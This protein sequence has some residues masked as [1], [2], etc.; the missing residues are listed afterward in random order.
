MALGD[1][2]RRNIATVSEEERKRFVTAILKL[3]HERFFPDGTSC[4]DKQED[5]HKNAHAAGANVHV[6]PAFIPWHRELCNRFE[7]L[8]RE[9]DADLSLHYW[10]WTVDPRQAP[11]GAGGTLDLFTPSFMGGVGDPVGAPFGDFE[12]TEPGHTLIWR[13]VGAN[14]AKSDGSP[15][16]ST[17]AEIK[18]ALD[19]VAFDA[20]IR[21]PHGVAHAY[22]GGTLEDA[23][24]SFHDPFVFLLHSDLDRLWAEWQTDPAHPERLDPSTAYSSYG[25]ATSINEDI[26]P[27]AGDVGT[28]QAPLRPWGPP[29]NMQEVKTYKDISVVTPPCYDTLPRTVRVL[30]AE[31][32]GMQIRFDEV[33]E[34]ET[35]VRAAVFEVRACGEVTLRVSAGPSAPFSLHLPAD[36]VL[37]MPHRPQIRQIGRIW[38]RYTAGAAGV[39]VPPSDVTVHCEETGEDFVFHLRA[40]SIPRPTVAVMLALDQSGSMAWPAGID[41]TTKRIDVLH[42]AAASFVQLVQDNNGVGIVS[43]DQLAHPGTDVTRFGAGPF[44]PGRATALAAIQAIEPAGSTSIG[45]GLE[46]ARSTLD[47]VSGYDRKALVVFTDGLENTPL[48]ISDVAPTIDDRTFAIGLGTAQQVSAGALTSLT[49]HTQ[50]YLLLSGPLS[51]SVDDYFRLTKYFLQVLAGVT[52]TDIVSD[53]SGYTSGELLRI[54]FD[55]ADTDIDAT[56][57]LLSDAPALRLGV[58]TPGGEVMTPATAAAAGASYRVTSHMQYYRFDLPLELGGEASHAG[59]WHALLEMDFAIVRRPKSSGE[60]R[61][62]AGAGA[63]YNITVQSLTNLRLRASV[64]QTGMTPGASL[65]LRASLSEYGVPLAGGAAVEADVQWPDGTVSVLPLVEVS[66]GGFEAEV[67]ASMG[68]VYRIHVRARGGSTSGQSFTREQLLSAVVLLG[69]D[70]PAPVSDPAAAAQ[71][72]ALCEMLACLLDNEGLTRLLRERGVDPESLRRCLTRWCERR[73]GALSED[74]LREREATGEHATFAPVNQGVDSQRII[75]AL[76]DVLMELERRMGSH[77]SGE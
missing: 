55:L 11:D 7:V 69:G 50:G 73:L 56:V 1:G 62:A 44:D 18:Q 20:N 9:V 63:R 64:S 15:E 43:F 41:T 60:T 32:P 70:A 38:F 49:N 34:S 54:P 25:S 27:W 8:L 66:P 52:N 13:H 75:S 28:G 22:I 53:P 2:I 5:I 3:D 37:H 65:V 40:N 71:A 42:Q 29:D 39:P 58:E 31:N 36:G 51:P 45:N 23:H 26:Q 33:P 48:W 67:V 19:F 46:L 10:D 74:E 72:R 68:G 21:G 59:R 17:D 35:A 76:S 61:G 6:G 30:T 77:E 12:S 14:D 16:I 47:G 57:V 4:F 24:Y